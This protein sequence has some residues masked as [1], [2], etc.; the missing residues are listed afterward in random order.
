[1][2]TAFPKY[3]YTDMVDE[4]YLLV[5]EGLGTPPRSASR[6]QNSF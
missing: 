6:M 1:M 2:K 5:T 4:Q 3:D